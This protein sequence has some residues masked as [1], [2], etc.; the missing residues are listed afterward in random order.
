MKEESSAA[1]ACA[2]DGG[3]SYQH[4]HWS[5]LAEP[6]RPINAILDCYTK[7]DRTG[8]QWTF[9]PYH[10]TTLGSDWRSNHVVH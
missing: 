4:R 2:F 3:C 5:I 9:N 7:V 8:L 6:R 1:R 10:L